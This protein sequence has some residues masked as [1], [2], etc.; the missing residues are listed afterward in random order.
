MIKTPKNQRRKK[1]RKKDRKIR[2]VKVLVKVLKDEKSLN[3]LLNF[4]P[5]VLKT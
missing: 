4:V 3:I 5:N 1:A 2:K